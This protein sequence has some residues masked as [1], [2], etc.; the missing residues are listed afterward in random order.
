MAKKTA[1]IYYSYGGSTK[2]EAERIAEK[3]GADVI[4]VYPVKERGIA[5]TTFWGGFE[6]LTHRTAELK[7]VD[8]DL[9]QYDRFIIGAPIWAGNPAPAFHSILDLIPAGREVSCYFCSGSGT[10]RNEQAV[11]QQIGDHR[12]KCAGIRQV[13]TG[14]GISREEKTGE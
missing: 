13:K 1:V 9:G 10:M 4:R 8:A 11:R 14:I 6:S 12:L 3:C 2:K 5:G 7:P